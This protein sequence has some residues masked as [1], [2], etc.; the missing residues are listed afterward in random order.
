MVARPLSDIPRTLEELCDQ[1]SMALLIYDMQVGI[2]EQIADA[3]GVTS[4]VARVLEAARRAGLRT[5]FTRHLSLPK[6]V[7]GVSQL[8]TAMD[9]Q[10]VDSVEQIKTPFLRDTPA[11]QLIPE[12]A[13]LSS[14]A[15]IDK[16]TM[17]AFVGTPFDIALR[18][19]GIVPSR[20]RGWRSRL[21]SSPPSAMRQISGTCR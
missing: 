18:D 3:A 13:P 7:A 5:F 17:S 21:G 14:E 6:E 16:I 19:C 10:D 8:R 4:R 2:V 15:V 11:F 1:S 20:S 9:W 12:I